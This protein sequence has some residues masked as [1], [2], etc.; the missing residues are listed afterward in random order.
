MWRILKAS[1]IVL[2]MSAAASAAVPQK[3]PKAGDILKDA[4]LKA[5][6]KNKAIYLIFGAYSLL[7]LLA[8]N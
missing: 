3:P 2:L 1:W 8:L 7:N 4:E 5:A 6:E